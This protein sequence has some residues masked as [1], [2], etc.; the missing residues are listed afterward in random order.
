M[1]DAPPA[2]KIADALV[3]C[4]PGPA[5]RTSA[6]TA[7]APPD[8]RVPRSHVTAPPEITPPPDAPTSDAPAGSTHRIAIADAGS[9]PAFLNVTS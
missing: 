1:R 5:N 4:V 6:V 3:W 2:V 8:G 9:G 7:P